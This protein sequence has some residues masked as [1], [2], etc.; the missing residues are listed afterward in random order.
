MEESGSK[1]AQTQIIDSPDGTHKIFW[2]SWKPSQNPIGTVTFVHG[3]SEHCSRYD[4]IFDRFAENGIVVNGF[5]LRGHGRTSGIRGHSPF[6][7]IYKDISLIA[8]KADPSLPHIIYGHSM[9]GLLSLSWVLQ[10]MNANDLI[11][12]N[13]AVITGPLLKLVSMIPGTPLAAKIMS[14]LAPSTTVKNGLK[15]TTISRDPVEVE[16]YAKDPL[17]HG[18]CSFKTVRD[19]IYAY[20]QVLTNASKYKLP[21]LLMH[22]AADAITDPKAT[23]H[24]YNHASSSDKTFKSIPDAYHEIHNEPLE[25]RED[26]IKTIL[27]WVL[28]HLK[29]NPVQPEDDLKVDTI[30][31]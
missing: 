18:M 14:T 24:F 30:D 4:A 17:N 23:E 11:P 21:L 8:S 5:D 31:K 3:Q 28:D 20:E 9:G 2:K 26:V 7:D 19:F 13:G 16:K 22:G 1:Y 10:H 29:N 27:A 12:L 25:V 6:E 15:V